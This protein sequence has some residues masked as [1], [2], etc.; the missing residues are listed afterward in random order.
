MKELNHLEIK[1]NT[2][3]WTDEYHEGV[4]YG[5]EGE[6]IIDQQSQFQ[7]ITIVKSKRYGNALLL[8]GC[9][10]TSEYK[11]KDY[12][13]CLVHPALSSAKKLDRILII[14]G[15]DGGSA[16]ECL[17]Y[18]GVKQ[19]DMIEIDS[20]VI[21]VSQRFLPSLSESIWDDS[22]FN[23]QIKDGIS[24]VS[25]AQNSSYDVV[26]ID[27]SD[28]IGPAKGLFNKDFFQNCRRILKPGGVF[29]SQSESPESFR[30]VHIN[31]VRLLKSIFEYAEPLYGSVPLY[32]S[33]SWSWTFA[34]IDKP[35]FLSP[36]PER[37]KEI[38]ARCQVW[39]PRWQKGAFNAI[40]ANIEREL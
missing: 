8:N 7:R 23:L 18:S 5:L 40:P 17:K 36:L 10:M 15:G 33:G 35:R 22:R 20:E 2:S 39:S 32:P 37:V 9:W 4:R 6:V 16:R 21:E 19:L 27:G 34:S 1:P 26:I 24:W 30:Q 14:G 25:N 29:S 38:A 31:M 11:E 28:P 13:E 3:S 12:H